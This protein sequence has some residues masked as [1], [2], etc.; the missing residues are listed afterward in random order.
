MFYK[1]HHTQCEIEAA[2]PKRTLEQRSTEQGVTGKPASVNDGNFYL[3]THLSFLG[4]F[5]VY[6]R[7]LGSA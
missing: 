3:L 7:L 5:I 2:I 4:Q 6:C 1:E